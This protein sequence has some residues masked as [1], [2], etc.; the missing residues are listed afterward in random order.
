VRKT[1]S[2][3]RAEKEHKKL[4]GATKILPSIGP[5]K[6]VLISVGRWRKDGE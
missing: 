3:Y 1:C 6:G 2:K 4:I 5:E